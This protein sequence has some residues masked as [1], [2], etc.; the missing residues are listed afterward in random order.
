MLGVISARA[1]VPEY[2]LQDWCKDPSKVPSYGELLDIQD[3]LGIQILMDD[4]EPN[5]DGEY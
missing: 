2:Q 5:D 4:S 3:A 1:R